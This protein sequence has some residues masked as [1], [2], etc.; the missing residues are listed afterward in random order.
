MKIKALLAAGILAFVPAFASAN[1][2]AGHERQAMSCA[3]GSTWDDEQAT[4]VP[5]VTG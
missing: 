3:E 4:C 2:S 1:C 5:V